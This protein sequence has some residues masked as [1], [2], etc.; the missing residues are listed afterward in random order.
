M[1]Q[2]STTEAYTVA[3]NLQQL[4]MSSYWNTEYCANLVYWITSAILL[5]KSFVT[6]AATTEKMK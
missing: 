6:L 1:C 4:N 5:Y 3:I 2:T